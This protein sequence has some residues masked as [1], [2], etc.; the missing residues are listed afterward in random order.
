MPQPRIT[1]KKTARPRA[2]AGPRHTDGGQARP[3]AGGQALQSTGGQ[4]AGPVPATPYEGMAL[5]ADPLYGYI[6]FTVPAAAGPTEPTEKDLMDSPWLQRL[7]RIHQL[8]STWWLYPAGEHSRFQHVLGVMHMA[9]RFADQL[10]PSLRQ[11]FPRCPSR[12]L[13]K[14]LLRVTGLVHDVGHGPF[15][16]FFDENFLGGYGLNHEALGQQIVLQKLAP[17]IRG[18][19]RGPD[20]PF[21]PGESLD[22]Q[23][24]DRRSALAARSASPMQRCDARQGPRW[25]GIPGV[26]LRE[27]PELD[28]QEPQRGSPQRAGPG[29]SRA[30][31]GRGTSLA[32][33]AL[34]DARLE[35][36]GPGGEAA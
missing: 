12:N 29:R 18:V 21:A 2:K 6:Q 13:V 3:P 15:S 8:Q 20:G 10:Y 17:A 31:A 34:L 25:L 24:A 27:F 16:H 23:H 5:L 32:R 22:P 35:V 9:D 30:P 7:R 11:L 36:G 26:R 19:R 14:E 28:T 4:A 1:K 33:V